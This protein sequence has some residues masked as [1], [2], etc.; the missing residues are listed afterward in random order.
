M[1]HCSSLAVSTAFVV[2]PTQP[3]TISKFSQFV[4]KRALAMMFFLIGDVSR[5]QVQIG[6]RHGERSITSAPGEFPV[7]SSLEFTQ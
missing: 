7:T 3:V 5:Y 4:S 2:A 1:H 6:M